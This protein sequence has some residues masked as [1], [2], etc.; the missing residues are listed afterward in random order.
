MS[1]AAKGMAA[2]DSPD[3]FQRA[4]DDA[5]F[6]DGFNEVGTAGGG[7]S[8]PR[9]QQWTDESL[10]HAHWEDDGFGRQGFPSVAILLESIR[11]RGHRFAGWCDCF[12]LTGKRRVLLV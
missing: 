8:A 11:F 7:K 4:P 10:V 6:F 5:M 3:S 12:F 1:A 2:A 9:A